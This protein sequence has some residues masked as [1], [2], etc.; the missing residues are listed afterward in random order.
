M[1]MTANDLDAIW[2]KT[3]DGSPAPRLIA[4]AFASLCSGKPPE[5]SYTGRA[6]DAWHIVALAGSALVEVRGTGDDL[7]VQ[8]TLDGPEEAELTLARCLPFAVAFRSIDVERTQRVGRDGLK[9]FT[10]WRLELDS[11][12]LQLPTS[13]D[14]NNSAQREVA[15]EFARHILERVQRLA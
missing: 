6:G 13:A 4:Q 15:E 2:P 11:G 7:W 5:A 9:W 14:F 12:S 1:E 3:T 10:Q 8:Q